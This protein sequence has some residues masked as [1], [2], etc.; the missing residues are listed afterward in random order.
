MFVSGSDDMYCK[1]WDIRL[2]GSNKKE[3]GVFNGHFGGITCV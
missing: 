3:V 1:L 2:L